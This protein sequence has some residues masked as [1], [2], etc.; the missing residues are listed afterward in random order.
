MTRNIVRNSFQVTFGA[1]SSQNP[2]YTNLR[3]LI[4]IDINAIKALKVPKR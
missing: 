3:S 2:E 4:D 1:I